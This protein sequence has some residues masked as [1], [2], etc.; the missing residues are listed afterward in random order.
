MLLNAQL[1]LGRKSFHESFHHWPCGL[2]QFCF[3][4]GSG[5]RSAGM[6]AQAFYEGRG[7]GGGE[8]KPHYECSSSYIDKNALVV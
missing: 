1:Q 7:G 8:K 5:K 3:I 2:A 4:T 6:N